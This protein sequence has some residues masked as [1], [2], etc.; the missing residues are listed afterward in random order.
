VGPE[1]GAPGVDV[2][3]G[4]SKRFTTSHVPLRSGWISPDVSVL[5]GKANPVA[6]AYANDSAITD[7]ITS[8]RQM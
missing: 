2:G 1:E 7:V 3:R 5:C 8:P 4:N 6:G